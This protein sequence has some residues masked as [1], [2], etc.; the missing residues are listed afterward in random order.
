MNLPKVIGF[1][2]FISEEIL[3]LSLTSVSLLVYHCPLETYD[4]EKVRHILQS[5]PASTSP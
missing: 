4:K 2:C 5:R 1:H 3:N